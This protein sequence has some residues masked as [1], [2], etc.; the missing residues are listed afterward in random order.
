M[1]IALIA[2]STAGNSDDS[3]GST[4]TATFGADIPAGSLL[5]A[6]VTF[7][8]AGTPSVSDGASQNWTKAVTKYDSTNT[9]TICIFYFYNTVILDTAGKKLVTFTLSPGEAFRRINLAAFSGV[10]TTSDPLD[11]TSSGS[12]SYTAGT[13]GIKTDT[14]PTPTTDGQLFYCDVFMSSA[15][16]APMAAGTDFS[17]LTAQPGGTQYNLQ[18]EYYIQPTAAAHYG[19]W[20]NTS[21]EIYEVCLATFKA[22]A[23]TLTA[24]SYVMV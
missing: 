5:V 6:S 9:Q 18:D 2:S 16:H 3:A 1:A 20:T 12:Q 7:S 23:S 10:Q 15:Q 11:K 21:T 24:C 17:A 13:D 4:I 22:T 8:Q 19:Q 14:N